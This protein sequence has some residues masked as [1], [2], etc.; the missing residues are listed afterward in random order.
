MS[1]PVNGPKKM[2]DARKKSIEQWSESAAQHQASGSPSSAKNAATLK[3]SP[4]AESI[5]HNDARTE[6]H[7]PAQANKFVF[8]SFSDLTQMTLAPYAAPTVEIAEF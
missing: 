1:A 4:R 6:S 5:T 7:P 2:F 3:S 8:S